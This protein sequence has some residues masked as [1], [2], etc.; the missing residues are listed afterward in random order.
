MRFKTAINY[1]EFAIV[2]KILAKKLVKKVAN[3]GNE[4]KNI[5]EIGAGSGLLTK[6]IL[7]YFKFENLILNDLY[8]SEIM[9][10]FPTQIGDILTQSLPRNLDLIISSSTLQWIED[11]RALKVQIHD[12]L[13]QFGMI[14]FSI[15]SKGNL[16]NLQSFTKQG[17]NYKNALEISTIFSD[18]FE[19]LE[20]ETDEIVLKFSSL[21]E[22]LNHLKQTGV[23]NINGKFKLNKTNLNALKRHFNEN[24]ELDYHYT[25]FVARAKNI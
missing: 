23:N 10:K 21:K 1:D 14:A 7:A 9:E 8:K 20:L 5:Y 11:L 25:I 16:S 19:I 4:F 6:E 24:Y 15:F 22:L 2:Q 17:L 13:N 18:K 3:Y 12:S